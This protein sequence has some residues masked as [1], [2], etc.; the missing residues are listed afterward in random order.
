[1]KAIAENLCERGKHGIK[2][3]CRRI[4]AALQQAYPKKTHISRIFGTSDLSSPKFAPVPN[5]PKL[6]QSSP[7]PGSA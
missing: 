2:Y 3:V 7:W 6:T 4:P 5:W 1:M